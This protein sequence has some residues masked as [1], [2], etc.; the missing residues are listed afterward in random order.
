M[1]NP[2]CETNDVIID[3]PSMKYQI[4]VIKQEPEDISDTVEN[5]VFGMEMEPCYS[6]DSQSTKHQRIT[7]TLKHRSVGHLVR[8]KTSESLGISRTSA[9]VPMPVLKCKPEEVSATVDQNIVK[10]KMEQSE[11]LQN[12]TNSHSFV[13][14]DD[15]ILSSNNLL[16]QKHQIVNGTFME[17]IKNCDFNQLVYGPSCETENTGGGID[18]T[19]AKVEFPI[20]KCE[21][22]C[23]DNIAEQNIVEMDI[24]TE[25]ESL[26]EFGCIGLNNIIIEN[27]V[28]VKKEDVSSN[29]ISFKN[30]GVYSQTFKTTNP[31]TSETEK[32][33]ISWE[34]YRAKREK[35][36]LFD[37]LENEKI[38]A[39]EITF[40][41]VDN[42]KMEAVIKEFDRN[43]AEYFA[44]E[45]RKIE[46][47]ENRNI[48]AKRVSDVDEQELEKKRMKI[49]YIKKLL[50]S[51]FASEIAKTSSLMKGN[52]VEGIEN[53][54][55]SDD[56]VISSG[57]M[58]AKQTE[59]FGD[60][61]Y[62]KKDKK[63]QKNGHLSRI[64]S[65][66]RNLRSDYYSNKS[67]RSS[68]TSSSNHDDYYNRNSGFDV[69]QHGGQYGQNV[70][71]NISVPRSNEQKTVVYVGQIPIRFGKRYLYNRFKEF[72]K[73]QSLTLHKKP[74]FRV[75]YAFVTY[76]ERSEAERAISHGN[77]D[78]NQVQ[79]DI[80]FGERKQIQTPYYDLDDEWLTDW[81]GYNN[82]HSA[83]VR[84]PQSSERK[85]SFEEE[86]QEF[87]RLAQIKKLNQIKSSQLS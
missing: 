75:Y 81:Y 9:V 26:N 23:V 77:H 57:K 20:V 67:S 1:R 69:M 32:K 27:E 40:D 60:L 45:K 79:F 58:H 48:N 55:T 62:S 80:R 30:D 78:Q 44:S 29:G 86:L 54:S 53:E 72:G 63:S 11:N 65:T 64:H 68:S 49:E 41:E 39:S 85:V 74:D 71:N 82:Q 14:V 56:S 17:K 37:I 22:E 50:P 66:R 52:L 5:N 35:L 42:E 34:E 87:Y 2:F 46:I 6:D 28:I 18:Q 59:T 16:A 13:I 31:M 47:N 61:V 4:P 70:R 84:K 12:T 38:G 43:T 19:W 76:A 21:P 73:I 15:G 7:N 51:S 25:D 24:E 36:G 3:Q 33:K 8:C 83:V 10:V